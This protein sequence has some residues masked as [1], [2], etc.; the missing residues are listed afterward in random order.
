MSTAA[1]GCAHFFEVKRWAALKQTLSTG[2]RGFSSVIKA[3]TDVRHGKLCVMLTV[4]VG[5]IFTSPL[6]PLPFE[7]G[8]IVLATA[9]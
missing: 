7:A 3:P 6:N 5:A 4:Y 9:S 2:A 8:I 1:F